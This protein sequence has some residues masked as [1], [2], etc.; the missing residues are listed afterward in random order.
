MDDYNQYSKLIWHGRLAPYTSAWC[1]FSKI[2]ALNTIRPKLLRKLICKSE[3]VEKK[4]GLIIDESSWID[5]EKFSNLL[6]V[7]QEILKTCFLDQLGFNLPFLS[8]IK[9]IRICHECL[10]QG[11]HSTFFSLT[12]IDTCPWHQSLL[13]SPCTCCRE[14]ILIN[15]LKVNE[16]ANDFDIELQASGINLSYYSDCGH[17]NFSPSHFI[18]GS[19]LGGDETNKITRS[20]EDFLQWWYNINKSKN[21]FSCIAMRIFSNNETSENLEMALYLA[22]QISGPCPWVSTIKPRP[23]YVQGW[24][25]NEFNFPAHYCEWNSEFAKIYKSIRRQIVT[26][27]IRHHKKCWNEIRGLKEYQEQYLS[28]SSICSFALAYASWR[29]YRELLSTPYSF[30]VSKDSPYLLRS[31]IFNISSQYVKNRQYDINTSA[32]L[33]LAS[34]YMKLDEIERMLEKGKLVIVKWE[35]YREDMS[36]IFSQNCFRDEKE[37]DY[38]NALEN[39]ADKQR[40]IIYTSPTYLVKRANIRCASRISKSSLTPKHYMIGSMSLW[41]YSFN[42][43][44]LFRAIDVAKEYK[45]PQQSLAF[46]ENYSYRY[47][48]YKY[49]FNSR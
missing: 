22:N 15:G 19:T 1:V 4:T 45:R 48:Y 6:S 5:F 7:D 37:L 26:R 2:L 18:S 3:L 28:A 35:L 42:K 44:I 10:S 41:N 49:L 32:Q 16:A 23:I 20:C 12:F 30:N 8:F 31:A 43:N 11:F 29:M 47:N 39:K 38:K 33:C 40:W 9:D 13:T 46:K 34:F 25:L 17:I 36:G 24:L 21:K 14:T 27:Y